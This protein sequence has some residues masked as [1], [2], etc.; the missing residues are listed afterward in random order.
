MPSQRTLKDALD[1]AMLAFRVQS[2][3]GGLDSETDPS[4]LDAKYSPDC[5][6]VKLTQFGRI[7]GRNGCENKVTGLAEKPDGI[8]FFY[9]ASGGRHKVLWENDNLYDVTSDSSATL[10]QAGAYT[11]GNRICWAVLNNIL[12][13]SDGETIHTGGATDSG[14]RQYDG[15][16]DTTLLTSGAPGMIPTPACKV[17]TTYA[18]S[19]VLGRIKYVGGTYAKHAFMWSNVNDPTNINATNIQQCGQGYGGE[20]NAILPLAVASVGVSP[21]QAILVGKSQFGIFGYSGA[22]G[23]L[24]EFLVN[25]P[26]GIRD[27]ATMQY[28]PGPDGSGYVVFLG[29]DNKLWA[30]NGTAAV[31]LSGPIRTEL[32]TAVSGALALDSNAIF[33]SAVNSPDF[34]YILDVGAGVQYVYHYNTQAW[35]RY[36]GWASGYWCAAYTDTSQFS[37]YVAARA[38]AAGDL[39]ALQLVNSG[40]TDNGD[41]INPYWMTPFINAGD[42]NILKIW[43]WIYFVTRTDIANTVITAQA[44]LGAGAIATKTIEADASGGSSGGGV[45][46]AFDWDEDTWALSAF[47]ST[48]MYR[49]KARLTVNPSTNPESLRG[50]DVTIKFSTTTPGGHF[51]ILGFTLLYLPRGRKRVVLTP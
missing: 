46:D 48:G 11:K 41:A 27:G 6:N 33:T 13:Y 5:Q 43:K 9:D 23:T 34:Q 26:T 45:W 36:K 51:E 29:T 32:Q 31:E 49:R 20:L 15:T 38:D 16:T 28:I 2:F 40:N 42:A 24:N 37:L 10:I 19:L 22:L 12:Y 35:T 17:M 30:V 47:G 8:A 39:K 50:F 21:F 3:E 18:G 14:I 1:D 7:I 4:D 25:C 44:N